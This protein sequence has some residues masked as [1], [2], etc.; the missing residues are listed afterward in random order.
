M[1]SFFKTQ[2]EVSTA[3]LRIVL[4]GVMLAHGFQKAFG[5]FGGAGFQ[6]TM[7]FFTEQMS[8][9]WG[10]ALVVVLTETLGAAALIV[11]FVTRL[12]ALAIGVL[13]SV[14]VVMVHWQ[15]GF[16]MNWQGN[17]NGEGF[18]FHLLGVAIAF[19]LLLKG[20]GRWSADGALTREAS[21]I[22]VAE[23]TGNHRASTTPFTEE[24][25]HAVPQESP[26]K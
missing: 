23:N 11:G 13:L 22:A 4:G 24:G 25:L 12:M 18:E 9:P 14:A 1:K 6:G 21:D 19:A 5:W 17:Q 16:F 26:R 15:Y 8:I 2:P 10:L 3:I 20:G 7:Q